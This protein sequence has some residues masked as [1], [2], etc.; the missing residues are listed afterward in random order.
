MALTITIEGKGVIA[1]ADA[2][3]D[4]AMAGSAWDEDGGGTDSFTTDTFLYGDTSFAGAYS[5]KSGYQYYDIGAAN[6]LDFDTAGTE[7]G[8]HIYMWIHCPTIGLLQNK[9]NKGLAIR[10]GTSLSDYREYLI[11]GSDDSNG[12]NGQWKCFIVDPTKPGSVTDTGSYDYGSLRYFGVWIDTAAL[13]KGDNIF[14]SQ[15]AV[16]FGLRI[17]GTSTIGWEDVVTYCTDY[18]NR[19]WGMFQEREGIYYTY[20]K[21]WI[22]DSTQTSATSFTD[23]GRVIQYGTSEYWNGSAWV[24]T[25]DVDSFGLVIEDAASYSTT[26]KDGVIVSTDKG[27][28]GSSIIG[29]SLMNVSLDLYGGN[30]ASSAIE[31]YGTSLKYIT[32]NINMGND[33]DH[34]FYGGS[35][36]A[37]SQFDPVGAPKLRNINFISTSSSDAALL[38]NSSIDIE[39]CSFIA[40]T[41]GA[42]I[43]ISDYGDGNYTFTGLN[44]SGNTADVNNTSTGTLTITNESSNADSYTGNTT[45]FQASITLKMTVSDEGGSPVVGAYAYIDN[46]DEAPYILNTTTNVDGI[47]S[48][49]YTGATVSGSRWRVRKYG[50]KPYR[51]LIDIESEDISVPITLVGDPQQT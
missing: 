24:T 42:A 29:N 32:G 16:G 21:T 27:R 1:N 22:G 7:E 43:E 47:A 33:A 17:T 13:A 51:Q 10:L 49:A 41:T 50:Y 6:V 2:S 5:N 18:P 9:A 48:V 28:S 38:W 34:L 14:I 4:T 20:G 30:S 25:A 40:N 36:E 19:A 3:P 8:Q 37:C 15:M 46:D 35:I 23:T 31:L 39:D 44:F 12:W 11:A 45:Y 26:F